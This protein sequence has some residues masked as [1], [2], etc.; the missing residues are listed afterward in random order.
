VIF[1]DTDALRLLVRITSEI[2]YSEESDHFVGSERET[3]I[4]NRSGREPAT[5]LG[6]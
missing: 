4:L 6:L 2:T 5:A 3:L 1:K